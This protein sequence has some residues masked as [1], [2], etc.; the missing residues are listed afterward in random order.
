MPL[1][2]YSLGGGHTY[3]YTRIQKFRTESI[4]ETRLYSTN[5]SFSWV[6]YNHVIQFM[7]IDI[8][9]LW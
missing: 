4:L 7:Q 1:V 2:S 3:T 5:S 6:I 9:I 8:G